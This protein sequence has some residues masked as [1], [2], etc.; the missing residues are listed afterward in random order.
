M[1]KSKVAH[2]LGM[3]KPRLAL[4]RGVLGDRGDAAPGL[5]VGAAVRTDVPPSGD[6]WPLPRTVLAVNAR[7]AEGALPGALFATGVLRQSWS[8]RSAPGAR[9]AGERRERCRFGDHRSPWTSGPRPTR[10]NS[11]WGPGTRRPGRPGSP[12]TSTTRA[13][14]CWP[15]PSTATPHP[16][17]PSTA[18][19]THDPRRPAAG[20]PSPRSSAGTWTCGDP[21]LQG[22]ERPHITVPMD[23]QDCNGGSAPRRWHTACRCPPR[24]PGCWPATR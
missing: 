1:C 5:A 15:R 11:P 18:A 6:Q 12:G 13:S 24:R 3:R 20:R 14:R 22:G 9:A 17:P 23:L 8:G 10:S 7:R 4:C 16:A 21:P 2:C 19:R